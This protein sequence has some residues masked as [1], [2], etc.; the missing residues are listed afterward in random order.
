MALAALTALGL[1]GHH[2]L[3]ANSEQLQRLL[4]GKATLNHLDTRESELKVDGYRAALGQDVSGDVA[5]DV[6]SA[7]EAAESKPRWR[8]LSDTIL[9][10]VGELLLDF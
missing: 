9:N 7:S 8:F 1:W 4:T 3:G 5:D 10:R 2:A 6:T